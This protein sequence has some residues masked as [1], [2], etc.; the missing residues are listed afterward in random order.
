MNKITIG[1]FAHA[2]AG[3][4]TVTEQLL[5]NAGVISRVG[6]VDHGDTV[7]DNLKV[8][9]ERGITVRASL[10]SF[11]AGENTFNLIDT[12]GHIDFVAEVERS[13]SV[14]DC[15]I[16]V[17]SGVEG[18][19][20]Q[21][22][23]IFK[24]LKANNIPTI[25]FVNKLDRKGASLA[26]VKAEFASELRGDFVYLNAYSDGKVLPLSKSEICEQLA[27]YDEECIDAF[28]KNEVNK[29]N[30]DKKVQELI[31]K[32]TIMPVFCGSALIAIGT[33][34]LFD[35]ISNLEIEQANENE[36]S[37]LVYQVRINNGM[38]NAYIKMFGGELSVRQIL[39]IDEKSI[40][41]KNLQVANGGKLED[42]DIVQAGDV[43][44]VQG[45]D[46]VCGQVLGAT[47][48]KINLDFH[49]PLYSVEV[50][51]DKKDTQKTVEALKI[52]TLED[53]YLNFQYNNKTSQ[54]KISVMGQVQAE[55]IKQFLKERFDVDVQLKDFGVIYK[56][57]PIKEAKA[58]ASYTSVSA[59]RLKITP[60]ETGAG[61]VFANEMKQDTVHPKYVKQIEKLIYYYKENSLH[62]WELT[63]CK[64]SLLYARSDSVLSKPMHYNIATPIAL[65]RA[66][67]DAGTT[68][69]EPYNRYTILINSECQKEV[70]SML[71]NYDASIE[72]TDYGENSII[73]QGA[74]PA[75][76]SSQVLK[77]LSV[78]SS[79]LGKAI[80]EFSHYKKT[81]EVKENQFSGYDPRN[82]ITFIQTQ[83]GQTC[84][85]LDK[86]RKK[87]LKVKFSQRVY[88]P[89]NV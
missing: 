12:P 1:V 42:V 13:M 62:G 81:A 59:V 5:H 30:I 28:L 45:T 53:Q 83:M 71:N 55:I 16:M 77:S 82:E 47:P 35:F 60:L 4:T 15:A 18:V 52:L 46:F 17:V 9:Q 79:G 76:S 32:G 7:T 44:I 20:A 66:L 85:L 57:K 56:E 40:K 54:L 23:Q 65:F 14:L 6:R 58:E 75:I 26:K 27:E 64:I 49:K 69:L 19:E 38:H 78:I 51:C 29:V 21:T 8:E 89:N 86:Q 24:S 10:V 73:I 2:N 80:F 74:C 48:S 68:L 61:L 88:D 72:T 11:N 25:V 70:V 22:Y 63:D 43:A 34:E 67:K 41:I 84:K 36:L 31:K 33:N 50:V 37:A 87:A 39:T 3:K